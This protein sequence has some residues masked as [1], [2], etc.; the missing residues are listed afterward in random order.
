MHSES[1]ASFRFLIVGA[2]RGGTSLLTG[3]LDGHSRLEAAFEM[4]AVKRLSG[5]SGPLRRVVAQTLKRRRVIHERVRAF[6]RDC[7]REARKHPGLLW[8]NK[9][10]TEQIRL[11]EDHNR[12]NPHAQ[13]DVLDFFFRESFGDVKVVFILRDGRACVRSKMTRAG[14]SLEEACERW[15]Y[16]VKVYKYLSEE[17]SNRISLKFEDLL[18]EPSVELSRVCEFLEVEY[19]P[20]MLKGTLSEKIP[21]EYRRPSFAEEKARAGFEDDGL[22]SLIEDE[23]R[24]CGYI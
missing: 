4:F 5:E 21:P 11:L 15:R 17:R 13:V 22:L 20:R 7:L 24:Y 2:G 6:K 10:T 23:M 16:S 14:L 9:I 12:L 18:R 3:L 8:G 1:A 19:E